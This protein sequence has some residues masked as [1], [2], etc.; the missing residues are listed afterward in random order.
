MEADEEPQSSPRTMNTSELPKLATKTIS[1]QS[2]DGW[3]QISPQTTLPTNVLPDET[4]RES[5]I[6][7]KNISSSTTNSS[8][9]F[10]KR[11]LCRP[12]CFCEVEAQLRYSSTAKNPERPF[13]GCPKYNTK[14]LKWVEAD[15]YRRYDLGETHHQL[16]RTKKELEKI[17]DEIEKS[18]IDLRKRV[19]EIEMREMV[20]SNRNEEV[21]N[22]E[23][24]LV[25]R[26]AQIRHSCKLLRVY[27]AAAFVV[28]CY[29]SCK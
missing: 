1:P 13:L 15:E 6:K 21:V 4:R 23:L 16:L 9:S 18:K 11:T 2:Y 25:V 10:G 20:L 24:A 12:L 3:A 17:L 8:S 19:D 29:L 22:K 5:Q 28:A 26:E 7:F 27:W 14:Y